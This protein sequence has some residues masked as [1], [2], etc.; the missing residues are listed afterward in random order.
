MD[1]VERAPLWRRTLAYFEA[2]P[3]QALALGALLAVV[4]GWAFSRARAPLDDPYADPL[5]LDF[6]PIVP[7]EAFAPMPVEE[8]A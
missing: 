2:R 4:G 1:I 7:D 3:A 6:A 8:A 5:G